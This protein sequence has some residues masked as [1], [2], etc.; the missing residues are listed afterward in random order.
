[1]VIKREFFHSLNLVRLS[2]KPATW[3]ISCGLYFRYFS[4]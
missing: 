4:L 1:M 3:A 2:E